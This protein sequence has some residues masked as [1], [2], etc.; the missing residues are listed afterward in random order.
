MKYKH[1]LGTGALALTLTLTSAC[2]DD[3]QPTTGLFE[4]TGRAVVTRQEAEGLARSLLGG[5]VLASER[6]E[7]RG[8]DVFEIDL[9]LASGGVVEIT[10][11]VESGLVVEVESDSPV[12][13]DDIDVGG[14]L[15]TLQEAISLA[16][17]E[18]PG[19]VVGWEIERDEDGDW[20]WEIEIRTPTGEEVEIEI[21]A[22]SSA[23]RRDDDEESWDDA[24]IDHDDVDDDYRGDLPPEISAAALAIVAGTIEDYDRE[25]EDGYVKW[26][27]DVRTS[28]G[29]IVEVVLLGTSARLIEAEGSEPPFDYAFEPP[30][31]VS[32]ATALSAAGLT[33]DDIE[34]WDLERDDGDFVYELELVDGEDVEVDAI[35]GTVRDRDDDEDDDDD[36]DDDYDDDGYEDD[37]DD[38]RHDWH[39][40]SMDDGS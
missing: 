12:E 31:Y 29:A 39:D 40:E 33:A 32:L 13:G 2:G 4:T 23:T 37:D 7:E 10:I 1:T 14:G 38:D 34:G 18:Q 25:T 35:D 20:T 9:L 3:G 19:T 6:D 24:D 17:A 8:V 36:Y 21:D 5:T 22:R 16:R 11:E 28:S 27:V 26:E 15:L 30:G